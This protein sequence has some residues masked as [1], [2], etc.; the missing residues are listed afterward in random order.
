[1]SSGAAPNAD[2]NTRIGPTMRKTPSKLR[3]INWLALILVILFAAILIAPTINMI[4]TSL[5]S[6]KEMLQFPPHII[7]NDIQF[8]NY[9]E[10]FDRYPMLT[11]FKNTL[12]ITVL[13]VI[14][15]VLSSSLVAFGF[16]RY[17]VRGRDQ[18]FMIVLGTMMIPY[19]AIMIPQFV[20]FSKIGW[21][22]TILPIVVPTFFGSAY[23]I[24]LLR[25]FF[26]TLTNEVFE[27]ARI[28]GCSEFRQWW[29]IA[30]PLSGPALATTGIFTFVWTWNDLLG[31]VLFLSST[32][33]LTLSVGMS[34]M[35]SS[36]TRILPWNLVMVV[37]ILAIIPIV[38][39]FSVAQRYFVQSI[40]LNKFK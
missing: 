35:V 27:A 11:W 40:V 9:L 2:M 28:D 12:V 32:E 20:L 39:L 6:S 1:M 18:L 17:R 23:M 15:T 5:K 33:K 34:G 14:G 22:D 36:T 24:F 7:P 21:M 10:V 16:S 13:S 37:S 3:N 19:P 38:I 8:K 31:Q 25:Q 26:L 4:S 30:I 29:N